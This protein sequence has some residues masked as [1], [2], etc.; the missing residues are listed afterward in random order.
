MKLGLHNAA[1]YYY[2]PGWQEPTAIV[3]I[4]LNRKA[5][6]ALPAELKGIVDYAAGYCY[7][8]CLAEYDAKNNAAVVELKTKH[9][10]RVE[11]HEFP[12]DVM[13][14]LRKHAREVLEEEAGKSPMAR[15]V[16]DSYSKFQAWINDWVSMSE[17]PYHRLMRS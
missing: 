3:E 2:Y 15:K 13:R 16:H 1:R 11:I 6:E 12:G 9:Q 10:G 5:Y 8:V 4:T 14:E 7:A 17:D